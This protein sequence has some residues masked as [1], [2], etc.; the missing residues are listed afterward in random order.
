MKEPKIPEHK[1]L[2]KIS[3]RSQVIGEFIDWLKYEK[4][5]V[6]ASWDKDRYY[7]ENRSITDFLAEFFEIDQNKIEA[8][9]REMLD[10]IRKKNEKSFQ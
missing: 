10:Y 5:V 4:S 1:K 2:K 8:E 9:K 6:L 7:L 3:G